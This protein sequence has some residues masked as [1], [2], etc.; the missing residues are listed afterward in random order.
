MTNWGKCYSKLGQF[1]FITNRGKYKLEQLFYYKLG[2]V[3]LQ[4]RGSLIITNRGKFN[5]ISG[6]LVQ[7]RAT[8]IRN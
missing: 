2:K 7:I 4:I 6:Q 3:L 5:Y 8:V 1:H